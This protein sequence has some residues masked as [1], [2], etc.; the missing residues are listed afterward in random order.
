MSHSI[1]RFVIVVAVLAFAACPALAQNIQGQVRLSPNN[2][3]GFNVPVECAGAGCSGFKYTDRQGKF[4]F[5]VNTTGQYTITVNLPGYRPESRS[6]ALLDKQSSEY[7]LFQLKPDPN[8]PGVAG[9]AAAP[10]VV[11]AIDP[12]VP[13]AAR[14]EYEAGLKE[15]DAGKGDKAIPHLEKAI[16]LYPEF[17]QAQLMLGTAYMDAKQWDKAE[18]ALRR[19]I[20]LDAKK[21]EAYFALGAL[22]RQQKKYAEAEKVLQ[23]GLK[24]EDKSWSGHETLARVYVDANAFDKAAPEIEK[25]LQLNPNYADGHL[26]AA[27][28]YLKTRNAEG[29]L[30][31]FEEYLRLEP[32]GKF[33]PQAQNAV[34]KL[35]EMLKK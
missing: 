11:S 24:I 21:P 8:A 28:I 22:Y 3:P 35:K 31:E 15:I 19:T 23:E 12:K 32:K 20:E 10:G 13:D 14:K 7:M 17:L 27:N 9:G 18:S 26:L 4:I 6:V 33:A 5:Y 29:A 1:F 16:S 25:T 30:K 2:T 34:T